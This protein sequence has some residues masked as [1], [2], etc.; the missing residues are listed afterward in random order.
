MFL[1]SCKILLIF[2]KPIQD[3]GDVSVGKMLV[4]PM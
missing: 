4:M 2:L 3:W 1:K